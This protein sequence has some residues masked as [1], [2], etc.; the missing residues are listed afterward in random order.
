MF[1]SC[2]EKLHRQWGVPGLP[3]D[4][5]GRDGLPCVRVPM[6]SRTRELRLSVLIRP[7]CFVDFFVMLPGFDW[8]FLCQILG[9]IFTLFP[10]NKRSFG[11]LSFC[12][13]EHLIP[14]DGFLSRTWTWA[15]SFSTL[16]TLLTFVYLSSMNWFRK[17]APSHSYIQSPS[18]Q[19]GLWRLGWICSLFFLSSPGFFLFGMKEHTDVASVGITFLMERGCQKKH[20]FIFVAQ[21][22]IKT[23][24]CWCVNR[25]RKGWFLFVYHPYCWI[26][27]WYLPYRW[28]G[29][30]GDGLHYI[31]CL[32]FFS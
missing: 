19:W 23:D 30:S 27:A 9:P 12:D 20:V 1:S 15:S 21:S 14:L 3:T 6:S 29:V 13:D 28:I 22:L 25:S 32:L 8:S 10:L 11:S 5:E 16:G 18:V 24:T 26:C 7:F 17:G 2:V 31:H 4:M